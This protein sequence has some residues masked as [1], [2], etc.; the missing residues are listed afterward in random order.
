[1]GK[2]LWE[3]GEVHALLNYLSG[4]VDAY[5]TGVKEQFYAAAKAALDVDGCM[6]TTT[7]IKTK[8]IELDSTYKTYKLKLAQS[9]FGVKES[10]STGIKGMRLSGVE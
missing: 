10:D 4:H 6:K 1:M 5:T 2:K 3:D 7:Q 8:L 9:G